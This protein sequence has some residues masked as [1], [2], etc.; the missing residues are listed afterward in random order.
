MHPRITESTPRS[1][2][3]ALLDIMDDWSKSQVNLTYNEAYRSKGPLEIQKSP[4]L[5]VQLKKALQDEPELC[6]GPISCQTEGLEEENNLSPVKDD[7]DLV[8]PTKLVQQ[9]YGRDLTCKLGFL[10]SACNLWYI[11]RT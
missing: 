4:L 6:F 11:K 1:G 10:P 7:L 8:K 9:Q 2:P 5:K 3:A